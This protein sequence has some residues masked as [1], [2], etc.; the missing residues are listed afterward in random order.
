MRAPRALRAARARFLLPV[1]LVATGALVAAAAAGASTVPDPADAVLAATTSAAARGSLPSSFPAVTTSTTS[2]TLPLPPGGRRPTADDPLRVIVTGDSVAYDLAE[3]LLWALN[4]GGQAR[5]EF[6]LNPSIARDA[7]IQVLWQ[8]RLDES[9]P[10][11]IVLLVGTWENMVVGGEG[12]RQGLSPLDPGWQPVYT[13]QVLEPWMRLI[14][15]RGADVAWVGMPA[16]SD[17]LRSVQFAVLNRAYR[18]LEPAWPE[19]T[20]L[21]GAAALAGPDGGYTDLGLDEGG[22]LVRWRN[23]DGLHLCV[24]GSARLAAPV[25]AWIAEQWGIRLAPGWPRGD[26]RVDPPYPPE[27]CPPP[28]G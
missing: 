6:V 23:L 4:N 9:D 22:R 27:E 3:P 8:R 14:T 15:S 20:Y 21:D 1:L 19:L 26:W 11:L 28:L 25:L 16:V 13:S 18:D 17:W 7:T 24:D 2:T 10:E 5:A 12:T